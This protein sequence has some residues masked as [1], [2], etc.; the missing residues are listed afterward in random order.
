MR[1]K[2]AVVAITPVGI[3]PFFTISDSLL[4][5]LYRDVAGINGDNFRKVMGLRRTT[6][7]CIVLHGL[8]GGCS[9]K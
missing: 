5:P 9:V 8:A 1:L 4:C 7:Q 6:M 3:T 2:L